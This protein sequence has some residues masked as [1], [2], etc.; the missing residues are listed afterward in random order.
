MDIEYVKYKKYKEIGTNVPSIVET[1]KKK[2]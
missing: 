2:A 1:S